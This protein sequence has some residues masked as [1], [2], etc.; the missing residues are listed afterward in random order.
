VNFVKLS[1][2]I[3]SLTLVFG[4]SGTGYCYNTLSDNDATFSLPQ[5]ELALE[6]AVKDYQL[7]LN[8]TSPDKHRLSTFLLKIAALQKRLDKFNSSSV[9]VESRFGVMPE[10]FEMEIKAAISSEDYD[11]VSELLYNLKLKGEQAVKKEAKTLH[12]CSRQLRFIA[13]NDHG[14]CP[15]LRTAI[16]NLDVIIDFLKA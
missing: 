1:V 13:V 14:G 4:F 2:V 8:S 16:D 12:N 3:F 15:Q 6:M 11:R 10:V 5:L 9:T 7:E